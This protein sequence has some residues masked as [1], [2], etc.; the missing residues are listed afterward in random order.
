MPPWS[1]GQRPAL[2]LARSKFESQDS[3]QFYCVVIYCVVLISVFRASLTDTRLAVQ[4]FISR[5][6][7]NQSL[8]FSRFVLSFCGC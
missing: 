6:I 2:R 8:K 7:L 1:R 5:K 4:K 3:H